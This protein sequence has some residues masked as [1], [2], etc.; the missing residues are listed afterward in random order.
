M[1]DEITF[2]S[3][4]T[5]TGFAAQAQATA[6]GEKAPKIVKMVFGAGTRTPNG[7]ET[8]LEDKRLELDIVAA[9]QLPDQNNTA[10]FETV[11][12]PDVGGFNI[13]EAGLVDEDGNLV[14]VAH[15]SPAIPKPVV[16]QGGAG[17]LKWRITA[18]WSSLDHLTLNLELPNEFGQLPFHS[19]NQF[20]AGEPG[21]IPQ[22]KDIL[23]LVGEREQAIRDDFPGAQSL[24]N[25]LATT[26]FVDEREQAIRSDFPD[27]SGFV[28]GN[29]VAQAIAEIDLSN[30]ARKD[31]A[32]VFAEGVQVNGNFNTRGILQT[33]DGRLFLDAALPASDPQLWL[34]GDDGI[35]R[36][37]VTFG[38]LSGFLITNIYN[39]QGGFLGQ[40]L[41]DGFNR[42]INGNLMPQYGPLSSNLDGADV[43][44]FQHADGSHGSITIDDFRGQAG[45]INDVGSVLTVG[46]N[47]AFSRPGTIVSASFFSYTYASGAGS[48]QVPFDGDN[49]TGSPPIWANLTELSGQW[50]VL[51]SWTTSAGISSTQSRDYAQVQKVSEV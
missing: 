11:L 8:E 18:V 15:Y 33:T 48:L 21:R 43:L 1:T 17:N 29:F 3:Q 24:P 31:R 39:N 23:D 45:G 37:L 38:R 46:L 12:P 16:A 19:T 26:T 32:E 40:E 41:F 28:T 5:T 9:G 42:R 50:L 27:V 10:W 30:Y 6:N 44:S 25:N 13:G 22:A 49:G 51:S 4:V 36:A 20:K 14:V 2:Y 35:H 47:D 34:R 7:T